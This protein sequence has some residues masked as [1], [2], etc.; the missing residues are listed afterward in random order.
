MD[1]SGF[2][3]DYKNVPEGLGIAY[4]SVPHLIW[5]SAL[6]IIIIVT[7]LIYRS[8]RPLIQDQVQTRFCDLHHLCGNRPASLLHRLRPLL[9]G[10]SAVSSVRFD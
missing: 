4:F 2:F 9:S 6:V 5:L 7:S 10:V 8:L 3:Y 1:F